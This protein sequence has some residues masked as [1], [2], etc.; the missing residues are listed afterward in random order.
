[1]DYILI[2]IL[3]PKCLAVFWSHLGDSWNPLSACV[4]SSPKSRS[5]EIVLPAPREREKEYRTPCQM[6]RPRVGIHERLDDR[7][8]SKERQRRRTTQLEGRR[9]KGRKLWGQYRNLV[10]IGLEGS[11]ITSHDTFA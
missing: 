6:L 9:Q 11:S 5:S 2:L 1:M 8:H 3:H 10:L 7:N 4:G